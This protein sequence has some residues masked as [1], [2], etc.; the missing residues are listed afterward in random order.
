MSCFYERLDI[1][2]QRAALWTGRGE[3]SP[4][5]SPLM[6]LSKDYVLMSIYLGLLHSLAGMTSDRF[7]PFPEMYAGGRGVATGEGMSQVC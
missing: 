6:L 4:R 1:L 7:T 2:G 3:A 5:V